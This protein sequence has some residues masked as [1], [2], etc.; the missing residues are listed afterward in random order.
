MFKFIKPISSAFV[1]AAL[2][3]VAC[4][5]SSV[6]SVAAQPAP[7][8]QV[9]V[10]GDS[11]S[12]GY[13]LPQES[14]FPTLLERALRADGLNV[15]VANAGVSGDTARNGLERLDWAVPDGTHAVIVEL[16]ANDMLR[17]ADP[18]VTKDSLDKIISR[19]K[20]RGVK[21][22]LAG[23]VASPS[24]GREYGDRFNAIYPDLARKHDV[25]LYPFFLEGVAGNRTLNLEDGMHPNRRGVEMIV[26]SIF[27]TVR[28]FLNGVAG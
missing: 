9:V 23:M 5:P 4:L 24:L 17:G 3:A 11:L 19:L 7:P 28:E 15:D 16:G 20:L 18:E 26:R 8:L 14:A 12:A 25:P 27:P 13:Q 22:M 10:L 21:V 6:S 1:I 2:L